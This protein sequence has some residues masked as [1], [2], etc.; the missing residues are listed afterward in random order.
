MPFLN[1]SQ[2]HRLQKLTLTRLEGTEAEAYLQSV[3]FPWSSWLIF[4]V[5]EL[6]L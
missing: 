6:A 4:P 2:S 5:L 3:S 1:P